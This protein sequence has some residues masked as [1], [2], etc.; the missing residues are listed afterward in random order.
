MDPCLSMNQCD[1]FI[2]SDEYAEDIIDSF[3]WSVANKPTP[4][5]IECSGINCSE[6]SAKSYQWYV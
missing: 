2:A 3:E 4:H 6:N 5:R 1:E